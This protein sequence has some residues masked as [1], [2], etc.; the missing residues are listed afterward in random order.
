MPQLTIVVEQVLAPV[1]G[2][3]GRYAAQIAAALARTAPA[4]WTVRSA[5]AWHR[6]VSA[7]R[8]DGVRGPHRLPAGARVL[9]EA[10]LYGLPPWPAG[11]SVHAT[12]P[13]APGVRSPWLRRRRLTVTVH[14]TVPWT[15]PE[16]LTPRGVSWHRRMIDRAVRFADAIVVPTAAVAAEL[17]DLFPAAADRIS[18]IPHGVTA[19][20]VPPDAD[21]R[22]DRM[23]LPEQ[24]VLSVATVE[25]RKGL[26]VLVAAMAE[27]PGAELVLTGQA[28]WG[29]VDLGS[30]ADAAGVPQS[31]IHTL[32]RLDDADL[33]VV[34]GRAGVLAVPSRAEGFGLPVLEGMAAGVAVVSSDAPALVEVGG[35]A[36]V[37]VP[38]GDRDALADALRSVLD[39][40]ALAQRLR[41]AGRVRAGA[42]SWD[43]AGAQLWALHAA[44]S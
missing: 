41:A 40:E 44:L 36:T 30:W 18:P 3:T 2:G 16:T 38:V 10:W 25:P 39:D 13:L 26:D 23:R 8:V 29:A 27:V 24:Y 7:A 22:A 5:V 33:A 1:P 6:D 12:T 15:H 31:R 19:L 32:G 34:L 9:N 28:G 20:D 37:V 42:F 21:A 17:A 11:D 4:D 35:G 43:R 14:D